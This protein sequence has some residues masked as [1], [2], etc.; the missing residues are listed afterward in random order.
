MAKHDDTGVIQKPRKGRG[1]VSNPD[2]RYET[3]TRVRDIGV[4]PVEQELE[5][6]STSLTPEHPVTVI[7]RND[8]PD[9][10]F[11]QSLN[12]YRGCEHGCVY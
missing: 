6:L 7:A 9:V 5:K 2:G 12:P 4:C 10:P 8:S 11:D 3:L 1:A